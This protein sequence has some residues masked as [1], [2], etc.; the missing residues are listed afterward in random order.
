MLPVRRP[1]TP[2]CGRM[3]TTLRSRRRHDQYKCDRRMCSHRCAQAAHVIVD[4]F[5]VK[6]AIEFG[7]DRHTRQPWYM[8]RYCL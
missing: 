3:H 5:I 8:V 6:G 4:T 2:I 7:I 1:I